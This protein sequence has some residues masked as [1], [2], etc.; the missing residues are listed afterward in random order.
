MNRIA[1]ILGRPA[2]RWALGTLLLAPAAI[3]LYAFFEWL[4]LTTTASPVAALSL[5]ARLEALAKGPVPFLLPVA[6]AQS[7]ASVLS[8]FHRSLAH[9]AACG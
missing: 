9:L 1:S 2:V 3:Y 5:D 7:V 8:A 4:F 6:L